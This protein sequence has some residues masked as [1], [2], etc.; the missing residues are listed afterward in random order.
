MAWKKKNKKTRVYLIP[1]NPSAARKSICD[2]L[3]AIYDDGTET[4]LYIIGLTFRKWVKAFF[5]PFG[6][7]L[8]FLIYP[9]G[10]ASESVSII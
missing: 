10:A 2:D 6:N 4:L 3:I 1:G 7:F 5:L 9:F 8:S